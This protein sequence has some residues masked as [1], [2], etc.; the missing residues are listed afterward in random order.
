MP[1]CIST[2]PLSFSLTLTLLSSL[3]LSASHSSLGFQFTVTDYSSHFSAWTP[4][5]PATLALC[6]FRPLAKVNLP[7]NLLF[8]LQE[9][10][11]AQSKRQQS[12]HVNNNVLNRRARVGANAL[13]HACKSRAHLLANID[14]KRQRQ[15]GKKK[16][17]LNVTGANRADRQLSRR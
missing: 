13:R 10:Q 15:S 7:P 3:Y 17:S 8:P 1:L 2:S 11:R 5:S 14:S 6:L 16:Q 9:L 4:V 12:A